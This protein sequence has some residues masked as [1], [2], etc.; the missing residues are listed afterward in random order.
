MLIGGR[1][2]M[3]NRTRCEFCKNKY[4]PWIHKFFFIY[5]KDFWFCRKPQ[6]VDFEGKTYKFHFC[7]VIN[8]TGYDCANF[9]YKMPF[10][11][12]FQNAITSFE[13]KF[14]FNIILAG[15]SFIWNYDSFDFNIYLL[16]NKYVFGF[17]IFHDYPYYGSLT[18]NYGLWSMD[19]K[20]ANRKTIE[21]YRDDE[22]YD[23]LKKMWGFNDDHDEYL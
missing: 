10:L 2:K 22:Y 18:F 5:K 20:E 16:N 19:E 6:I 23:D 3:K 11:E 4:I 15:V 21:L 13:I 8:E 1:V 7:K 14:G 12:K 17:E 9:E